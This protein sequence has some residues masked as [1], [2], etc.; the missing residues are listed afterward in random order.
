MTEI[1]SLSEQTLSTRIGRRM[2]PAIISGAGGFL[3]IYS[4]SQLSS[5]LGVLLLVAPFG[6]SS[7]LVFALPQSPLA[8]PK[9][10]IGGHLIS[11]FIGIAVFALLGAQPLSFALAVGLAIAAM[12][13]TDTLH[14]P[15]GADPIVVLAT[16]GSW[17]FLAVPILAGTV[18]IVAAA[19]CYHRFVSRRP[20]LN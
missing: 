18:L 20:Y 2:R 14:P 16:G 17:S 5:T 9:N 19:Y 1:N 3:A 15:A 4:L 7:V 8:Q 10:V 12:Q 11:A 13:A 6:A